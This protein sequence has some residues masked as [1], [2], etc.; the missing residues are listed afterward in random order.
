MTD[1]YKPQLLTQDTDKWGNADEST[2]PSYSYV[3]E[4]NNNADLGGEIG[5]WQ[6]QFSGEGT[7]QQIQVYR[8]SLGYRRHLDHYHLRI[9]IF[10]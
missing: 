8:L 3:D 9:T 7:G 6:R 1:I 10:C 2:I 5:I 4:L